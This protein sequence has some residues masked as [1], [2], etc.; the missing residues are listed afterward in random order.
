MPLHGHT[1]G[2]GGGDAV[3]GEAGASVFTNIRENGGAQN[4]G[5]Q[6]G[7]AKDSAWSMTSVTRVVGTQATGVLVGET[8]GAMLT[9]IMPDTLE[10]NFLDGNDWDF[11]VE[12]GLDAGAS[13]QAYLDL[14][15]TTG[16][17]LRVT[18]GGTIASFQ[19]ASGDDWHLY[20]SVNTGQMNPIVTVN[21]SNK[22]ISVTYS[23]TLTTFAL[24]KAAFEAFMDSN[25]GF[26]TAY[27][28]TETGATI[29]NLRD[30]F[31]TDDFTNGSDGQVATVMTVDVDEAVNDITLHDVPPSTSLTAIMT[32]LLATPEISGGIAVVTGLSTLNQ[33]TYFGGDAGDTTDVDFTGG[34]NAQTISITE[35]PATKLIT[36]RYNAAAD[37]LGAIADALIAFSLVKSVGI[38][39]GISTRADFPEAVGTRRRFDG[40]F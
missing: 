30:S 22:R 15:D 13:A 23:T 7:V 33:S 34:V 29:F 9:M 32:A 18:L 20:W 28:G 24:L 25:Y 10:P 35:N 2:G 17:G 31:D 39:Y 16:N 6:V 40:R 14:V 1:A 3:A 27:Q 37:N 19:G 5:L 8:A 26:T 11:V 21:D 4:T 12:Q 38:A 36:A